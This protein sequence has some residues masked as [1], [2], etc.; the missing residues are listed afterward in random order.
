MLEAHLPGTRVWAFGSRAEGTARANSDLD[1]VVFSTP[2]QRRA[3]GDLREAL[4][5]SNLPFRVDL[6]VWDELP[7]RFRRRIEKARIDLQES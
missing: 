1:L 4:E 3:V 6:H 5:E 7:A 2:D